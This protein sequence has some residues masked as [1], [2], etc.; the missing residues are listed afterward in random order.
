MDAALQANRYRARKSVER[1]DLLRFTEGDFVLV[2]RNELF[3]VEKLALRWKRSRRVFK[4]LNDFLLMVEDFCNGPTDDIQAFCFDFI[5]TVHFTRKQFFHMLCLTSVECLSNF[6]RVLNSMA[7][8][9]LY[10][11]DGEAY[12]KRRTRWSL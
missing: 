9:C 7:Q 5:A 3:S 8:S 12:Q 10:T 11:Y 4:A 2:A 1:W 6:L